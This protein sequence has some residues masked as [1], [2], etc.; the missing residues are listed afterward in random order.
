M[1]QRLWRQPIFIVVCGGIILGLSLG[2]RNV[3][4]LFMLPMTMDRGWPRAEFG[5]ALAIQNLVWGLTQPLTGMIADR[6]GSA[7]VILIGSLLYAVGLYLES[8][9]HT[10]M[11]MVFGAGFLIGVALAATA[12]GAVYG[13]LSR[14]VTPEKRSWALGLAGAIGGFC[15]F[16]MVP[17]THALI[18]DFGWIYALVVIALVFALLS[19]LA[20]VLKDTLVQ[21][22]ARGEE[23][24]MLT[25]IRA[26]F[27]HR[28]FWLL[29]IGFLACGFQLAFIA[30]HIPA[31]L[32]DKGLPPKAA[33]IAL[34]IIS[35]TNVV[36]TYYCG[37]FGGLFRRKYV[38]SGLYLVRSAVIAL[39][40]L[41]PLSSVTLYGFAFVMG[42]TWLGTVPLTNGLVSQLFGV[43]YLA[44][45]FGF[46]F[47]G[48]QLGAFLGV[49]LG[50]HIFDVTKSYDLVWMISI[51][52]GLIAALLH[53]PINDQIPVRVVLLQKKLA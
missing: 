17:A 7:Q 24:S 26:A 13:A 39:F 47:F 9:A 45:L 11:Q 40:M 8:S 18:A 21:H 50:A 29:N 22:D 36:G 1:T 12:F 46:V 27:V 35:L 33:V 49:W 31:Y 37:Y 52:L 5:M 3:Q 6:F 28:G 42:L 10:A 43:R 34:A 19:P 38:L 25:A 44:T 23:Q 51:A 14:I 16:V 53:L 2:A 15:Q 48:H 20:I 32:Q 4:G 41:L 30:T